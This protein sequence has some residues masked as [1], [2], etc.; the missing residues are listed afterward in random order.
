[1]TL[2][3]KTIRQI[4]ASLARAVGE[5]EPGVAVGIAQGG[6]MVWGGGR[7]LANRQIEASL[8]RAVGENEPGIAVGIAQGGKMVWGGGRGLANL[9]SQQVFGTQTP[10]RICSRARSRCL[11]FLARFRK[12]RSLVLET[13]SPARCAVLSRE[14][15]IPTTKV[16]RHDFILGTSLTSRW[17]GRTTS[18][19]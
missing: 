14:K 15:H 13:S 11:P 3:T 5:N 8:A 16:A 7:G 4:E 6:K 10:F 12:R 19:I 17:A 18:L 2:P 1:M 9:K